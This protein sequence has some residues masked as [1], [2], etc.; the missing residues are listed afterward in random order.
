M[1]FVRWQQ[2]VRRS[3][4][5]DLGPGPSSPS[6]QFSALDLRP[7]LGQTPVIF[8][9]LTLSH[10]CCSFLFCLFS[11]STSSPY[12]TDTKSPLLAADPAVSTRFPL[13]SVIAASSCRRPPTIHG[14]KGICRTHQSCRHQ[15]GGQHLPPDLT[16]DPVTPIP[17]SGA[18][19]HCDIRFPISR[20]QH[21]ARNPVGQ[22]A[23]VA[24]NQGRCN[25]PSCP[26]AVHEQ[27]SV[28]HRLKKGN[29]D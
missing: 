18:Y 17:S 7:C 13:G 24:S 26:Y 3:G 21:Q 1:P 9:V 16:G 15:R 27:A 2:V 8:K 5:A 4:D 22:Q 11:P 29:L 10:F 19:H 6:M 20:L 28:D 14:R 23:H 12:M 25:H